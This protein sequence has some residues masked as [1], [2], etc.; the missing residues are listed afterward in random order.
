M[1]KK[2]K[3]DKPFKEL[4]DMTTGEVKEVTSYRTHQQEVGYEKKVEKDDT[5]KEYE[6]LSGRNFSFWKSDNMSDYKCAEEE[7]R[8]FGAIIKLSA[9]LPM[10]CSNMLHFKTQNEIADAIGVSR[11]QTNE[12]I[13][14]AISIDL[15]KVDNGY[16]LNPDIVY[17][18]KLNE[19]INAVKLY[20]KSI[21]RFDMSLS[22][23]GFLFVILPYISYDHWILALNPES[24][25]LEDIIGMNANNIA[26]ATGFNRSTVIRKINTMTF[27]YDGCRMSVFGEFKNPV[28]GKRYMVVNPMLIS[29]KISDSWKPLIN[30]FV[31]SNNVENET[32]KLK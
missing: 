3:K 30:L 22:N 8:V 25:N 26:E 31:I 6:S 20:H 23:I 27:D 17:R 16:Y 13:Q 9:Y 32:P 14:K 10:D 21:K 11:V 29:R 24:Q 28:N 15:I 18:G 4:L 5:L 12:I 2:K 19:E 7:L 1:K